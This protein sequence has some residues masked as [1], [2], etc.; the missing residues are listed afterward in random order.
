MERISITVCV[1][2]HLESNEILTD[3][4]TEELI[5]ENSKCQKKK[6]GCIHAHRKS[7]F[8]MGVFLWSF[9]TI[10]PISDTS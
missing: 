7:D 9:V 3:A 10:M 6:P 8:Y 1:S 2:G 5:R 4:I